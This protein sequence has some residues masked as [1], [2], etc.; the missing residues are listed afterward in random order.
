MKRPLRTP[1]DLQ[2]LGP[3]Q[4][5]Q[6]DQSC[7]HLLRAGRFDDHLVSGV[8]LGNHQQRTCDKP[9]DEGCASA[10]TESVGQTVHPF[11]LWLGELGRIWPVHWLFGLAQ[12]SPP[13]IVQE[14]T[15]PRSHECALRPVC[16]TNMENAMPNSAMSRQTIVNR[17]ASILE[18][19]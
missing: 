17:R 9:G 4:A 15:V 13:S 16:A 10:E 7:A 14:T 19:P 5:Y 1:T 8:D 12:A 11:C 18:V 3:L 2:S 6:Q